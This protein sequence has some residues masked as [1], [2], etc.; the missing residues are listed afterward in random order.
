M[1]ASREW[2]FAF[3]IFTRKGSPKSIDCLWHPACSAA[4]RAC[5][6]SGVS[7]TRPPPFN[8]SRSGARHLAVSVLM[9]F[10]FPDRLFHLLLFWWKCVCK[11]WPWPGRLL[12]RLASRARLQS[13]GRVTTSPMPWTAHN[14]A[15]TFSFLLRSQPIAI[16]AAVGLCVHSLSAMRTFGKCIRNFCCRR[17]RDKVCLQHEFDCIP[18][19]KNRFLSTVLPS[20]S[21]SPA[22][23]LTQMNLAAVAEFVC[24]FS[25]GF[26]RLKLRLRKYLF[27]FI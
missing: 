21:E 9:V 24:I 10:F 14:S 26:V 3:A 23:Q 6:A 5:Y 1:F 2:Y 15:A 7:D 8:W 22:R 18:I 12:S 25:L 27:S 13:T 20:M 16:A 11:P 4:C 19:Y 17:V